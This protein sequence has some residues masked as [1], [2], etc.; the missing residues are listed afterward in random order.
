MKN[1]NILPIDVS[2][3][4]VVPG[5]TMQDEDDRKRAREYWE[6]QSTRE[7]RRRN[8]DPWSRFYMTTCRED[9]FSGLTPQDTARLIYAASFMGYDGI[10]RRS[11]RTKLTFADFESLMREQLSKSTFDRF[12]NV[13]KERY[14]FQNDDGT[15]VVKG[16]FFRGKQKNIDE[17]LTKIFIQKLQNLYRRTKVTQHKHLGHVFKM[18]SC[19][20]IQYNVVCENPYET[21]W[22]EVKPVTLKQFCK[23]IHYDESQAARLRDTY[24]EITFEVDGEPQ[25]FCAFVTTGREAN[26]PYII[27]NPRIF[28][29]GTYPGQVDFLGMFFKGRPQLDNSDLS[30]NT[31]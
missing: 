26:N 25:Y 22:S 2:T 4:E 10:L 11:E 31:M 23:M 13:V 1:R 20:N 14:I 30:K 24:G 18:L 15:L 9:Q 12:W 27:I 3:G 19:I 21:D 17:R 8:H 6:A 7:A 5:I 28:Y 16:G 29:A